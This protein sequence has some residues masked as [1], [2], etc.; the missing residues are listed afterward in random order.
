MA[1]AMTSLVGCIGSGETGSVAPPTSTTTQP[2]EAAAVELGPLPADLTA[3]RGWLDDN[4]EDV[5]RFQEVAVEL[6]APTL[7][8]DC[9]AVAERFN[10]ELGPVA[11]HLEQMASSPDP[12]LAELLTSAT[13]SVRTMVA[14]CETGDTATAAQ[15]RPGLANVLMLIERR[16]VELREG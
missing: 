12:V 11:E 7:P 6:T 5:R 2:E 13:I 9:L 8:D 4:E 10:A 16:Q 14:A 1:I 15:E 3:A